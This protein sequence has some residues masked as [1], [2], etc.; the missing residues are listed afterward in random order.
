VLFLLNIFPGAALAA[1]EP[2]A[3]PMVDLGR[4]FAGFN[5]CIVV[6]DSENGMTVMFDQQRC[7]KRYLPCSTY[8]IPHALM[9]LDAGILD[10]AEAVIDSAALDIHPG[11][12]EDPQ[13]YGNKT[14]QQAIELSLVWYFQ[15]LARRLGMERERA[16]L[17]R[18]NYGNMD[19]SSDLT[20][21][22]LDGGNGAGPY[23]SLAIS[24][25][26]QVSFL[27]HFYEGCLGTSPEALATVKQCIRLEEAPGGLVLSG[28]TGSGRLPRSDDGAAPRKLGWLVG[29]VE[30]PGKAPVY[31]ALNLDGEDW[32]S[33]WEARR[34]IAKNCLADLGYWPGG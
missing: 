19:P 9:A 17:E 21:F 1:A 23:G 4:H 3:E 26:E 11:T 20:S 16:Y 13:K 18:F 10:G 2:G 34:R 22:W 14:L 24:A 28:K 15:E 6:F 29:Y 31:Y 5:G 25:R 27:Q 12:G 32:E 7:N 8:K 30:R 33:V